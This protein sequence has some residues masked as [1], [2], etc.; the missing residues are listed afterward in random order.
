M[1]AHIQ[2][3]ECPSPAIDPAEPAI[4]LIPARG[5]SKGILSKNL[6]PVGGVPLITRAVRAAK[7]AKGLDAVVVSTDDADIAR[8]AQS[9]GAEVVQ[10]PHELAGDQA[11]SES[12]LMHALVTLARERSLPEAFVF[13]QCTSPFT[14]GEQIDRVLD[15][16]V[17]SNANLAFSVT[18]WHGFLWRVDSNGGGIGVNHDAGLPRQRRQD[19]PPTYLET[20]AIYALRTKAFMEQQTRFIAP[21]LPVV[22]D[23]PAPEIDSPTDLE[24]CQL[25]ASLEQPESGAG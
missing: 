12:A 16:L 23:A 15:E 11:S 22:I 14:T 6:Q 8:E 18:P 5:G 2:L 1:Q 4:A 19:L 21:L 7:N 25:L 3:S 9:A 10:R 17:S 20:G 24:R 13:L